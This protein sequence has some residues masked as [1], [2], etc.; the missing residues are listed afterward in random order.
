MITVLDYLW[1]LCQTGEEAKP[2]CKAVYRN[3]KKIPAKEAIHY[4]PAKF[5]QMVSEFMDI[6]PPKFG[7]FIMNKANNDPDRT[8]NMQGMAIDKWAEFRTGEITISEC[9]LFP[10]KPEK[11]LG[12]ILAW[13]IV[14]N[15]PHQ[16]IG[17]ATV[18]V[19]LH[20]PP[21]CVIMTHNVCPLHDSLPE[22]ENEKYR[23]L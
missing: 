19:N 2:W 13:E 23:G 10:I 12:P 18:L 21:I 8:A 5:E 7:D 11:I 4:T 14:P 22:D 9:N 6:R 3:R 16:Y 15:D 1:R 20:L 17:C